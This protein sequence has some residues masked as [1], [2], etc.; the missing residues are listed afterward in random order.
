MPYGPTQ[1]PQPTLCNGYTM[2]NGVRLYSSGFR[3]KHT[4]NCPYFIT[5]FCRPSLKTV[6]IVSQ[7]PITLLLKRDQP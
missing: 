4:I 3:A 1:L 5:D 2:D 7:R 6:F